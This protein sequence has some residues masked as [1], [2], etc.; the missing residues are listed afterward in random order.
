MPFDF[1]GATLRTGPVGVSG[2]PTPAF[3]HP[4]RE[5][6]G[7]GIYW[8]MRLDA[9]VVIRKRNWH[10]ASPVRCRTPLSERLCPLPSRDV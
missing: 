9:N 4:S 7:E 8:R 1:A 10:S 6:M 3:G 2:A 5:G